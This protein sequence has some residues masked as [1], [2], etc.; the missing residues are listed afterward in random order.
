[1]PSQKNIDQLKILKEKLDG[2]KTV[3]FADYHGLS[4]NKQQE[5]RAKIQET[6]GEFT[7]VKN[8]L[9]KLAL[10]DK[11]ASKLDDTFKG[12]TALLIARED[13]IGPLKALVEFAK[14]NE[15]PKV[16]AG[17]LDDRI[18]SPEE[19]DELAKLPGRIELQGKLIATLQSPIS[20]FVNVLRGNLTGLVQ[21]LKQIKENQEKSN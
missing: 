1:M 2:A 11:H 17:I 9:L 14:E 4:V 3:V 19:I 7:V 21:A 18:I 8:T 12:A 5:L 10:K 20:G 13:E 16:K 15:L 6:A